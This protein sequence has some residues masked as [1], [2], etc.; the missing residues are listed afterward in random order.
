VAIIGLIAGV[1]NA[2]H[3]ELTLGAIWIVFG[4]TITIAPDYFN[5]SKYN[6]DV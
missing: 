4:K 2:L 3:G 5:E 6:L 1:P